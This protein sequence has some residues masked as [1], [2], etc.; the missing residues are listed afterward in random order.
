MILHFIN[1]KT[2][3]TVLVLKGEPP[4]IGERV[5]I[6]QKEDRVD[7]S[8]LDTYLLGRVTDVKNSYVDNRGTRTQEA[9]V[10]INLMYHRENIK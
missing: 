3:K 6:T 8:K 10:H 4:R 5:E 2:D 7:H 1:N 9:Y